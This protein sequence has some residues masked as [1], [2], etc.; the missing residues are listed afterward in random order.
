MEK[1]EKVV[2]TRRLACPDAVSGALDFAQEHWQKA[3]ADTFSDQLPDDLQVAALKELASRG[4]SQEW[5]DFWGFGLDDGS[6]TKLL[7]SE[8]KYHLLNLGVYRNPDLHHMSVYLDK[9]KEP[10]S[11]FK[12]RLTIPIHDWHGGLVGFTGRKLLDNSSFK[13]EHLPSTSNYSRSDVVYNLHRAIPSIREQGF[14]VIVEGPFDVNT[15][16]S[17]GITNTVSCLG[18][19]FSS[20]HARLLRR[21]TKKV[22]FL[23]DT[24]QA[25]E[26]GVKHGSITMHKAGLEVLVA[27]LPVP[28]SDPDKVARELGIEVVVNS[29]AK[30]V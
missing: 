20:T 10:Y 11:A 26:L 7:T 4:Y 18:T 23:L 17:W 16:Y 13:W 29:I 27:K 12:N 1:S 19:L 15:L 22:V 9:P 21:F 6:L 8:Q 28:D 14:A 30:A 5:A 3:L 25:G 24:D 2:V